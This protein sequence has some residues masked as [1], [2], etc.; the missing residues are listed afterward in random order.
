MEWDPNERDAWVADAERW[1][2]QING[3]LQCK[4][5]IDADGQVAGVH[6]VAG[7]ERE[8]RHV[9]RDV[10]GLL[11]ARLGVDVY[12]KKIGVVQVVDNGP[13][14]VAAPQVS[15][16]VVADPVPEPAAD[17]APVETIAAPDPV[18]PDPVEPEPEAPPVMEIPA[19]EPATDLPL[20]VP[21]VLVAEDPAARLRC[22]GVG[23][24]SS[25]TLV[26]AEVQLQSGEMEARGA[27]EGPN[28][29]GSDVEL[30]A[31][32]SLA[33]LAELLTDPVMLH[34]HDVRMETLGG[35]TVVLVAVDLVEGRRT[36]TLFG[37]CAADHNRQQAIV[38]AILDA[39]NRRL[40]LIGMKTAAE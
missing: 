10:E 33:A 22:V 4:I 9:V 19:E 36:E 18:A 25:D 14:P 31:R 24:M 40:A 8:P 37:A 35:H 3:I 2:A 13:P 16:P 12:Y 27:E 21:A 5:D 23:V 29:A 30:V 11:K 1:I 20:P 28:H 17:P 32:A 39:L 6:V 38:H 34:L 7:M 26:R 15:R